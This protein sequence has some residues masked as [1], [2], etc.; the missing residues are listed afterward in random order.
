M[1]FISKIDL[2]FV[3]CILIGLIACKK[4]SDKEIPI[5]E[6]I[7]L[8]HPDYFPEP[9]YKPIN[10][11]LTKNGIALGRMLFYDPIL[12]SDSTVSCGTCHS[13]AH[14]F[15]GHNTALSAG[16]KNRKGL[17]N[18]PALFNLSWN[19][20]FMADG[21]INHI[22]I[23][24]FAPLTN[25]DEMDETIP[26]ILIKLRRNKRYR[27]LFLLAFK[28]YEI[29]DQK[30]FYALAQF[31][32]SIVSYNSKYDQYKKGEINLSTDE[33]EGLNTFKKHCASCHTEPLFTDY[34]FKN[35]GLDTLFKDL[36]RELIS[37]NPR[38]KGRFKVPSLRNIAQTHLICT[39]AGFIL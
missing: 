24:P 39:M 23:M 20:S 9:H 8:N 13:Q 38:D 7:I 32:T 3:F 5:T 33:M 11:T 12:S 17:R 19:T 28:S 25:P 31:M 27:D 4:I 18:S 16:V 15:S 22:E 14:A 30:M 6:D 29:T 21:G 37:Q 2:V 26:N 34:S 10:N 35:N 36:G 1:N